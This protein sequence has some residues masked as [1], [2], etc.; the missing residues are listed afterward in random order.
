[1]ELKSYLKDRKALVEAEMSKSIG[2]SG[3][4]ETLQKAMNYS[5]EAGGKRLRPILVF[6]GAE[7]VGGSH[8]MV[9]PAAVAIEMV[10]TFSLIH[11]DLPAMDD[12]SLRRGKPTN[13]K[14]FGEAHAILSGDALLVEAFS[15]LAGACNSSNQENILSVVSDLAHASGGRGMTGGQ[16]I[17]IDS[18]NRKI[19]E[20]ELTHLH[21][22]KTGALLRFSCTAGAKLCGA[23][24]DQ[25]EAL[26][27]YGRDI[28]LAF[29][30][31]DD[32]LDIEGDQELLGKD[33]GSDQGNL[34]STFP[35]L[36]GLDE[37]K[38]RSADLI[39]RAISGLSIFDEKAEPLRLLAKYIIE[40]KS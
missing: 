6:A 17:D 26:D 12:D 11:D 39:E 28:G 18:T 19:D 38:K 16:I 37:S 8:D 25:I 4:P 35:S 33:V 10:H 1:M 21:M 34:K 23:T 7:A 2:D 40:R 3:I 9:M 30:I 20:A 36:I 29:Q 32:I 14:V 22:L 24:E 27:N 15:V 13:H 31:A 5:L